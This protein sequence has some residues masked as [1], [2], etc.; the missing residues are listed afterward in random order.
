[1]EW[2]KW[3]YLWSSGGVFSKQ[4]WSC[5][6]FRSW[7]KPFSIWMLLNVKKRKSEKTPFCLWAWK[8]L[9]FVLPNV[10]SGFKDAQR[11]KAE[12]SRPA[13]EGWREVAAFTVSH[14]SLQPTVLDLCH[15]RS[16]LSFSPSHSVSLSAPGQAY[17]GARPTSSALHGSSSKNRKYWRAGQPRSMRRRRKTTTIGR[18]WRGLDKR[19]IAMEINL[20]PSNIKGVVVFIT[21]QKKSVLKDFNVISKELMMF[22]WRI[23]RGKHK[24]LT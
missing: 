15:A 7:A 10:I 1:M 20:H 12:Q 18:K 22:G 3:L 4:K 11:A 19:L 17:W 21:R 6:V 13:R 5:E 16:L 8:V 24:N 14:E 2:L 9:L 23:K